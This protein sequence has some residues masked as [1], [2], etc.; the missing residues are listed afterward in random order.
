MIVRT[1]PRA[2]QL[3]GK[4]GPH[5]RDPADPSRIAAA[6]PISP[7]LLRAQVERPVAELLLSIAL[8]VLLFGAAAVAGT[9]LLA[10]GRARRTADRRGHPR[11]RRTVP[12]AAGKPHHPGQRPAPLTSRDLWRWTRSRRDA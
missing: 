4:Q 8:V 9:T 12:C 5:A 6:V 1:A 10:L 7:T 11:D 3:I 2:A